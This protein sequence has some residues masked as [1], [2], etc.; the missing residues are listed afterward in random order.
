[1]ISNPNPEGVSCPRDELVLICK[2]PLT[3]SWILVYLFIMNASKDVIPNNS[4]KHFT[5]SF[6]FLTCVNQRETLRE[7]NLNTEEDYYS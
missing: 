5:K 7:K 1:M 4:K 6:H 3:R 2:V